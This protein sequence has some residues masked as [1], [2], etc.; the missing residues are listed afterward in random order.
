MNNYEQEIIEKK[1]HTAY[2]WH[3]KEIIVDICDL[4]E[5]GYSPAIATRYEVMVMLADGTCYRL[6]PSLFAAL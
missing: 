5:M 3:D 4:Y 2:K 6:L 1:Y